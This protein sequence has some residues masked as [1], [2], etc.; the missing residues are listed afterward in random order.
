MTRSQPLKVLG[1]APSINVRKVMWTCAETA[2]PYEREDWGAG[3]RSTDD[4]GFKA[5]N[6]NALVPVL[7]DGDFVLWESNTICRYLAGIAGRDDLLPHHPRPRADVERWMD[8][9]AGDFNNAWRYAFMGL[10]RQSPAH[11]NPDQIAASLKS[12]TA[13][14]AI[15]DRHIEK[16]GPFVT[17]QHFTLADIV[18]GLSLHR[19]FALPKGA[20]SGKDQPVFAAAQAYYQRLAARPAFI[21]QGLG[22]HG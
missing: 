19:W 10:I 9:Q 18:L 14:V 4:A 15:L 3:F 2:Q 1:K 17:G 22:Q 5:L 11:Q 12:W 7:I 21:E 6:P 13:H 20:F 16:T 8:W